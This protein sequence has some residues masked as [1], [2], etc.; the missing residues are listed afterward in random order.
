M[1]REAHCGRRRV[2]AWRVAAYLRD[3]LGIPFIRGLSLADAASATTPQVVIEGEHR[4]MPSTLG[5]CSRVQVRQRL[6]KF[7]RRLPR[8]TVARPSRQP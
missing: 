3:K 7:D 5:K 1:L 8:T 2:S 4:E 6:S